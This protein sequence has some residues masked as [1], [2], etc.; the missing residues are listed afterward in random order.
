MSSRVKIGVLVAA[1][2]ALLALAPAA[3]A[4]GG[5]GGGGTCAQI[6]SFSNTPVYTDTGDA[7]ITTAYTVKQGCVDERAASVSLII[8]NESTGFTGTS[9]TMTPLGTWSYSS[10]WPSGFST[11]YTITLNVYSPNG[12]LQDTQKQTVTS[13]D[14]PVPAV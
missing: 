14:A 1:L 9:V 6:L 8:K 10:T 7:A 11:R 13:L 3:L 5:D 2:G 4:K 12:K